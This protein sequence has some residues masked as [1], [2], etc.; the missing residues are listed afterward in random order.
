[1]WPEITCSEWKGT[2]LMLSAIEFWLWASEKTQNEDEPWPPTLERWHFILWMTW[3]FQSP[4]LQKPHPPTK[5]HVLVKVNGKLF[6]IPLFMKNLRCFTLQH[7]FSKVPHLLCNELIIRSHR[8]WIFYCYHYFPH[9][10]LL[11]TKF[12]HIVNFTSTYSAL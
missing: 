3:P 6:C 2:T 5:P 10:Q 1:M 11:H 12:H 4:F 9:K 8:C 7:Y